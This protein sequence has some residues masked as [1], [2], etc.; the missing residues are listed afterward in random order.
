MFWVIY[1]ILPGVGELAKY[2][3]AFGLF[4]W[5]GVKVETDAFDWK[6]CWTAD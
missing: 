2:D 6:L 5:R 4:L 1:E 3:Q